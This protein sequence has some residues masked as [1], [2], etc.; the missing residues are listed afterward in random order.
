MTRRL[1]AASLLLALVPGRRVSAQGITL[2]DEIISDPNSGAA[3]YGFDVVAYFLEQRAVPGRTEIQAIHAGKVWYFV[4][5]ANKDA[6]LRGPDAFIPV[7]GG[8]DP[9]G[10]A[11]GFAVAGDPQTFTVADNRLLLF[12]DAASRAL[13]LRE[14]AR[15]DLANRNWPLVRHDMVP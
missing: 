9:L 10:I 11:A 4:S 14:P 13:L 1:A 5:R 6:F 12:R 7:F 2:N 15:M 8:H 3:L